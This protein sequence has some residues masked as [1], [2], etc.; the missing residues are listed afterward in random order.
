MTTNWTYQNV[1]FVETPEEY[2]GFVYE[3]I[4]RTT[5]R[6]YIGKKNFWQTQI[7]TSKGR[8]RRTKKPSNWQDYWSSSA[9]VQ[10]DVD[11]LGKENFERRI[12][13]LCETKALM[14]YLEAQEQIL[15]KVLEQPHAYYNG[16]VNCRVSRK[17]IERYRQKLL[18]IR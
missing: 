3:I 6:T 12:L 17:H 7:R 11:F 4:C 5:G 2:Q 8:T 18:E 14:G 13:F 15:R 9:D 16:I 1:D 10:R